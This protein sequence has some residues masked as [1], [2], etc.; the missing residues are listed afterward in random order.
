M[1]PGAPPPAV[2][3]PIADLTYRNYEGP[4]RARTIRWW[5]VAQATIRPTL[6][7]PGFWLTFALSVVPGIICAIV[8]Y[9]QNSMAQSG[10]TLPGVDPHTRFASWMLQA[11][12]N[13]F[14]ELVRFS[15]ALIV[16]AG[17]I[18]ADNRANALLIYLSRPITKGDYLLGKWVGVFT[19]LFVAA[20]V[21]VLLLYVFCMAM[22]FTDGFL[23]NEPW[24]ILRIVAGSAA[25][26]AVYASLLIGLSAWSKSGRIAGAILAGVYFFSLLASGIVT[27]IATQGD[28][29]AGGILRYTSIEGILFGLMQSAY[30]FTGSGFYT[31]PPTTLPPLGPLVALASA[32]V[33]VGVGA[34]RAR[35]RAVEVVRG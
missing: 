30:H 29:E 23:Q 18:A 2:A 16:G 10:A 9:I 3:S 17:C 1:N 11:Q 12:G 6:S 33:V 26:A 7:K 13:A 35:V 34:A 22:F 28:L 19:V 15:M 32:L 27:G 20:L 5:T 21:P 14:S 4:I 25:P 31:I 8:I 24:L